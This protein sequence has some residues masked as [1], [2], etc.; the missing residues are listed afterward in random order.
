VRANDCADLRVHA[1]GD[2]QHTARLKTIGYGH[3]EH[4][5]T[6]CTNSLERS[7]G[8]CVAAERGQLTRNQCLGDVRIHLNH[9]NRHTSS[10]ENRPNHAADSA[11]TDEY[12]M[13]SQ[14]GKLCV[15]IVRI[16][17]TWLSPLKPT[18]ERLYTC[19]R[20]RIQSYRKDGAREDQ[21][22]SLRRQ[23]PERG[24]K[25]RKDE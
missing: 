23:Q 4:R 8:H 7:F 19:E 14:M 20:E 24:P 11:V 25:A 3:N 22:S 10:F 13:V 18:T 15:A 17:S 16:G 6:S 9:G 12:D 5:R 2:L 1:T 21:M